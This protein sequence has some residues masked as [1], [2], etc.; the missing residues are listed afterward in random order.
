M[1]IVP[2]EWKKK[3]AFNL[4]KKLKETNYHL[5]TG[6]V[7][8]PY[9]CRVYPDMEATIFPIG[10][11]KFG[12]PSWLYPVTMVQQPYGKDGIPYFQTENK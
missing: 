12:L 11:Y 5:R 7:G 3:I 4:R 6:F 2:D 8:T 1:D 9:L 10:F